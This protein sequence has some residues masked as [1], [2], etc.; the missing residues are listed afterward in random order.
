MVRVIL[1]S[2]LQSFTDGVEVVEVQASSVKSLVKE[3]DRR[4]P[5]IANALKSG[6]AVAI[7]GEVVAH[8][9]YERIPEG[10]EVHVLS[11]I[12]GG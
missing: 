2:N 12:Q 3:L 10:A 4:Y 6:F 7:N 9:T 1:A 8:P 11:A 5:G